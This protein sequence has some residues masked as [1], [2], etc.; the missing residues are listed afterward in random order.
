MTNR[1]LGLII[2]HQDPLTLGSGNSIQEA[3]QHMHRRKVGAVL[4]VEGDS[5]VGIFTGR[6]AVRALAEGRNPQTTRLSDVMTRNPDTISP[7]ATAIDALRT[8]SDCGYRHM[9]ILDGGRLVGIVSRGDF[10]G[11][12]LD[13][14]ETEKGLWETIC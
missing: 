7:T 11:L 9:P 14:L 8:M 10:Q 6:D 3:C 12:E 2:K 1:Q 4:V 13:K 5:L